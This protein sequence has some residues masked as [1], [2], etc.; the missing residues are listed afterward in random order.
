MLLDVRCCLDLRL[1]NRYL[2]V[3]RTHRDP[4]QRH[5]REVAADEALLDGGELRLIVLSVD[6]DILQLA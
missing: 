4:A 6:I 5:K 3:I 2:E 1:G